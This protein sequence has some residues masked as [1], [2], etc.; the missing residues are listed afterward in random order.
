[1]ERIRYGCGRSLITQADAQARFLPSHS[2]DLNLIEMMW[3]KVK[4]MLRKR[5]KL[6]LI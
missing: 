2:P 6:A 4:D 5:P 1:M 3:S